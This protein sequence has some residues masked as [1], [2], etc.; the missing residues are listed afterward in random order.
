MCGIIGVINKEGEVFENIV[1]GLISLQHRGQDACGI[2]TNQGEEFLIKKEIDPV[3]RVFSESDANKLKGRIGIG[4]TRYATQ[5]RGALSDIQPLSTKTLPK[6]AMAHNGNAINYFELKEE[7]LKQGYK[8]E[9]TVDSELIL[10]IF[11]YKY[12]KN[13]DFFES[14]KE[15]F[16][17]VKGSYALVGVIADKGLFAIRDPHGIRPLVLGKKGNSYMVASETVA[18]QVSDYEF[19]RDIAP[20]EALFISKDNLK[21]ESEIILE[22]EKAHCM[23]EWVYFASPN[24]MIEGRSVYK[25]RL[26]LGKLLS[27][28]IDKDKIEVILPV[29]DSGRTAAIKL[30]EEAGI[31]Y[32]EGLIKDRYSQRTFIMSSQKL[33]EKAVKSKLRPVISILEDKRVAVVDDSIVRGTTSRN[34]VKT[35]KQGGVKEITFIS[36][37]P[38]IRYPCFY[39]ID[40]SST[41]EFIA[42]NKSIDEI[43]IFLEAD[44]L[45][46]LT[47][48]DLKKA[49]RRD[50]CMACLTGEYPDN[51]TE[52]QKQKLSSQRVSEQTT[53][54]NKLNVLII[55]SGGREHALA[56]KVSESRL[57]NKLFAVPG[58]PGIAEIAECNNI[59]I[60]DNNALVNFAKEK[61][62]DLVIVGPE[63][64]LSNGIVDAFEAAGIRA[65][66]PNK[67]AAQFEG[68][69]SFARRFMHKYNLP[70]VEFRE[71]T[72]FSEAEKYIKE[73]GAPIV[74]KADGLAAGKGAFVANTE[75]E[76]VDFAKECLI[77]N[78]FGQ[79]SSKI[80]VEECLIGEEASYLVFMD[81][82]TF[83]PM[84]YSQDHKPVFE[85]DKGPNTGGMGA[86]SPAPILDSHEKELEEKI[87]KPFL[88][89]IKQEG[90]D[91]KGVLYVGLMKTN[92]GLKILEF[93]CRFGDPETQIILPRLKTDI[94]D[95][96]NA[97]IDKKLGS[98]RLDWSDEHCVAVVLAS[99]GYPGSYEK[100]KRITGLEDVEGVHII[101]AGTKKENGNIYTNG[102]RVL[103]V[104]ALAPTL[105]QAVDK[106]YS[107]IPKINFE[108][109][110]FRR[111]IAKK[112]LDRQND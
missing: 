9:T 83:S 106:A 71:F 58:N 90:I 60:I 74:V 20:G 27:D 73:K 28:Y 66:G 57:L 72:D 69:K 86:Y 78:R 62:I 103:N 70:S 80:I 108:G 35:L 17:K 3:H 16:E 77:N 33:R 46:Y 25:A 96:M 63:D 95:V 56:L 89:G 87:I 110:Y 94:I 26:A 19:V 47:I 42:A 79:A 38:P 81:S 99:G 50:V 82:E 64:P 84:V 14:A 76:A 15:V 111:D 24:S 52:E 59:D 31:I 61:D 91:F 109:M 30:S 85:G 13:K 93:N 98:I 34:I 65:F 32:R 112:E 8:L 7:F 6:I 54:D 4:H 1:V 107:N 75:E 40:M 100:G 102:G 18:F 29:P 97:V 53:L 21:M 45:I 10:K 39:G 44:N 101:Q 2:I 55:G 11:A 105:K 36:S 68:S 104:V 51:P 49:I 41:N 37:C 5:G 48:D 92:R 22:K 67:K 43:K 88:K 23:F 12:Q